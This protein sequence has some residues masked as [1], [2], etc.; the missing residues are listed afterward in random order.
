MF[1]SGYGQRVLV[2]GMNIG[3]QA[4]DKSREAGGIKDSAWTG[5]YDVMPASDV[6]VLV[7]RCAVQ[8]SWHA[9]LLQ[10]SW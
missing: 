7:T 4:P 8:C 1:P 10:G 6:V 2:E 9:G 3:G 5:C